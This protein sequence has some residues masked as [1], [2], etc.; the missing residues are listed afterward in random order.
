MAQTNVHLCSFR[1]FSV[2]SDQ[3][4]IQLV[5]F[6][7]N[8]CQEKCSTESSDGDWDCGAEAF[9]PANEPTPKKCYHALDVH[10]NPIV[11][12][13]SRDKFNR[14]L[15][16][17]S[18]EP[19]IAF[20]AEWKPISTSTSDVA[21]IQLATD[22]CVY[23]IDVVVN[24]FAT[25]DWNRLATGVFDNLEILKLGKVNPVHSKLLR[26]TAL[27]SRF[28]LFAN[29]RLENVSTNHAGDHVDRPNAAVVPR[30]AAVLAE[31]VENFV[32]QV[33]VRRYDKLNC[34]RLTRSIG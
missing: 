16:L 5:D 24:D 6:M 18:G 32:V 13:D 7:Q 8:G 19:V 9:R 29:G 15:T 23:L 2:S 21:L 1:F 20:D 27:A 12:V 4:P 34:T 26:L 22:R 31:V 30:L 14:M 11:L 10:R 25:E 17:L 28:S 3:L 33:S